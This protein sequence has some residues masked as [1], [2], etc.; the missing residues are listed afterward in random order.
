LALAFFPVNGL[1]GFRSACSLLGC[2]FA[3]FLRFGYRLFGLFAFIFTRLGRF[4]VFFRR[5]ILGFVLVRLVIRVLCG[6]VIS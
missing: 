2:F 6:S 3:G 1:A 4:P 5:T